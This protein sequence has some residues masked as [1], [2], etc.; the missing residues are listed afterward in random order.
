MLPMEMWSWAGGKLYPPG[1]WVQALC[2]CV[3]VCV[4]VCEDFC[5]SYMPGRDQIVKAILLAYVII[6]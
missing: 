1:A 3:C 2:V 6:F 4:C 5:G